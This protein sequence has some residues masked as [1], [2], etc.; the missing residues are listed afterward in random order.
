MFMKNLFTRASR[1]LA[2]LILSILPICSLSGQTEVMAWGNITGI[3]VEGQLMEFESSLRV[4][5]KNW[6]RISA[7]GKE[8]QHPVYNREGETQ[9]V[10]TDFAGLK[11]VQKVSEN[12][13]GSTKVE[14]TST[15]GKDT[16]L[17]GVYFCIDLPSKYYS[18]GIISVNGSSRKQ[19]LADKVSSNE[20]AKSFTAKSI[21]I[22]SAKQQ[23]SFNFDASSAVMVRKEKDDSGYQLYIRLMGPEIQKDQQAQKTI[24]IKATGQIDKSPV[25]ITV[26]SKN[27]GRRFDGFGGNFR[28][29]NPK[30]DPMVIQYCLDNMRVAWGRVEMPW[31]MWQPDENTRSG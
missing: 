23:L 31:A 14:I 17:S 12:G 8:R 4:A 30:A 21:I 27:P 22:G 6:T 28:L 3:R 15:A 18:D 11:F 5:G 7:T 13:T 10:N 16:I 19:K 24:T 1:S 26:D 9:I 2:F 20:K 25:E 29:Q